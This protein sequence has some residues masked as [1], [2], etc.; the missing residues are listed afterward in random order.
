MGKIEPKLPFLDIVED[1]QEWLIDVRNNRI[2]GLLINIYIIK[3]N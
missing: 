3:S 2:I 1:Y